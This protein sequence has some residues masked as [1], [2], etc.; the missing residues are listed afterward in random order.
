[1]LKFYDVV[2]RRFSGRRIKTRVHF[3][4]SVLEAGERDFPY[5]KEISIAEFLFVGRT[6]SILRGIVADG[7]HS[8]LGRGMDSGFL[9][10]SRERRG[11]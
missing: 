7:S 11:R 3:P 5:L 6:I 9:A 1:M 4:P 8:F 10:E 2:I